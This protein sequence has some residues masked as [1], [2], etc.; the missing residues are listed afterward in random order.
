MA[1]AAVVGAVG[2]EPEIVGKVGVAAMFGVDNK[3]AARFAPGADGTEID[4]GVV[5]EVGEADIDAGIGHEADEAEVEA[6]AGHGVAGAETGAVQL[7]VLG[8]N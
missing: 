5:H 8:L 1:F 2:A 4:A 7:G 3:A 6:G